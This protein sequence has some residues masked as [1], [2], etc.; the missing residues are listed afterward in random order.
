MQTDTSLN[1]QC[2]H[3]GRK[4]IFTSQFTVFPYKR[5]IDRNINFRF[6]RR[7]SFCRL[8][9]IS[10]TIGFT[11]LFFQLFKNIIGWIRHS[12]FHFLQ[13]FCTHNIF[14]GS[15][16]SLF[17]LTKDRRSN[18]KSNFVVPHHKCSITQSDFYFR[19]IHTR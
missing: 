16:S 19:Q 5:H 6:F 1:R 7:G 15:L 2:D 12:F 14:F 17:T 9:I 4:L 10:G 13:A 11:S 3:C 8:A 18:G